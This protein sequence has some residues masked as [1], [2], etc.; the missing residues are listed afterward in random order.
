MIWGIEVICLQITSTLT[1]W[2]AKLQGMISDP[3]LKRSLKSIRPFKK[4]KWNAK[5]AKKKTRS[6]T[7]TKNKLTKIWSWWKIR[8]RWPDSDANSCNKKMICSR[9]SRLNSILSWNKRIKLSPFTKKKLNSWRKRFSP[10]L[11]WKMRRR[12]SF[13]RPLQGS[14]SWSKKRRKKLNVIMKLRK[15]WEKETTE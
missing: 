1:F 15:V 7:Q 5:K 3:Y 9:S 8:W 2:S 11:N 6:L 4:S 12:I 13:R 14:N 10:Q